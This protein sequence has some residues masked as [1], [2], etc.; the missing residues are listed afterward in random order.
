MLRSMYSAISGMQSF[1]TMLDVVGNN[2]ANVDTYGFK[3]GRAD[4]SDILS[5]T[6]TGGS[7]PVTGVAGGTNPKQVGLGVNVAAIETLFTPGA[8]QTT[9]NPTDLA[10]DGGGLFV[11]SQNGTTTDPLLLTRA[12]DFTVDSAGNVVL[13]SGAIAMG[14]DANNTPVGGSTTSNTTLKAV[15]LSAMATA[16]LPPGTT[17]ANSPDL[18]LGQDGSVNVTDSNGNRQVIGYLALANVSNPG[19]MD[20]VGDSLFQTSANSGAPTYLMPG[21]NNSGTLRAGALEMSNVDLTT[22]FAAMIVAQRGFDANS[23]MIGTDNAV[24]NDIVNLKNS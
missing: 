19:G 16:T 23:H 18:Q 8:D 21:T 3:S 1:E 6:V 20:K 4:F 22:E 24:L 15:N 9:G 2:I 14:F 13:P 17:L 11:V 5:Q 12:G 10:I 7:A